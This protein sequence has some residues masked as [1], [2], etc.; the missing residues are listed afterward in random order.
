MSSE[1]DFVNNTQHLVNLATSACVCLQ[2]KFVRKE[3]FVNETNSCLIATPKL[4]QQSHRNIV[5]AT[6][7]VVNMTNDYVL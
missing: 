4:F 6:K 1:Q 3:Q 5:Q 2:N 7:H